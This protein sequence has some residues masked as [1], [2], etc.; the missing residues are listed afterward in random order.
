VEEAAR[1]LAL[2]R[3]KTYELIARGELPV[4]RIGRSLRVPTMALQAWLRAR[5][6]EQNGEDLP[7]GP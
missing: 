3:S 7:L 2:G 6:L 5:V 1:F 4:I